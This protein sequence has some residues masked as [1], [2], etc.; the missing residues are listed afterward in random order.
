MKYYVV[1]DIHGFYTETVEALKKNGFFD[2]KEPH[3]LIVCGDMMDRGKEAVKMQEFMLDLL[4]K[5]ELVFV[6]GNHE[7]LF[8]EFTNGLSRTKDPNLFLFFNNHHLS[9]RT[10]DTA[11]Q[12]CG[13]KEEFE[14]MDNVKLFIEQIKQTPFYTTLVPAA[15]NYFETEHYVFVHGWIPVKQSYPDG[16]NPIYEKHRNW[17]KAGK[18]YW[19]DARWTNGME[20]ARKGIILRNKTIVCGHIRTSYGHSRIDGACTEWGEDA[21]FSPYYSKGIIALDACTVH[22]EKVNCLVINDEPLKSF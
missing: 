6:R 9:N 19:S 12:L 11:E 2:D 7:D 18:S 14:A 1:S 22:S 4:K 8:M 5:D 20:A 21:D 15:V 3:K 16:V 13:Y 17:R 10:Y